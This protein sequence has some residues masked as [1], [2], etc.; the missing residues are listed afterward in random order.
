MKPTKKG[1]LCATSKVSTTCGQ[2][3]IQ[4]SKE[5]FSM[6]DQNQDGYTDKVDLCD[7]L[8]SLGRNLTD[9]QLGA[10]KNQAPGPVNFT[11]SLTM[12]R[13]KLDS[14]DPEVVIQNAFAC[15]DE[16]ATGTIQEDHLQELLTT[17]ED[18]FK[19]KE[20]DEL[21]REAS[22]DKKKTCKYIKFTCNDIKLMC[23]L[24]H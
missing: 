17:V 13:E 14:T 21:Y 5:V 22:G 1:S 8:V 11:M 18:R 15:S 4:E 9:A 19:D 20:V 24:K 10:V 23:I 6:T 16:E 2:A 3:Q 12:S 7:R